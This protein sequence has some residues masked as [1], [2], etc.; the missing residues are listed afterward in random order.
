MIHS[1]ILMAAF[2][3]ANIGAVGLTVL[4][5]GCAPSTADL[6]KQS[7]ADNVG[8]RLQAIHEI[9]KPGNDKQLAIAALIE[10]LKDDN[11]YVRRD[12]ARA[13]GH[14]GA[15]ASD[16]VPALLGRLRDPE[17]SVR[18]AVAWAIKEI[19]PAAAAKALKK[20]K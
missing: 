17:P 8:K 18:K 16:A 3:P 12:A 7:T 14:I 2:R 5:L 6:A 1:A 11:S 4:T 19:D 20:P 15:D 10:A 9:Q 13:L